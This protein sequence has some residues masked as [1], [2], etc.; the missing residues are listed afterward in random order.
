MSEHLR[1]S[2]PRQLTPNACKRK[3]AKNN[4]VID[5]GLLLVCIVWLVA[6][7]PV[8]PWQSDCVAERY[9]LSSSRLDMRLRVRSLEL[10]LSS[11]SLERLSRGTVVGTSELRRSVC[12]RDPRA[13]LTRIRDL[14]IHRSMRRRQASARRRLPRTYLRRSLANQLTMRIWATPSW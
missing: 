12:S 6:S 4:E 14:A 1:K 10:G 3:S 2:G 7:W 13:G 5:F 9:T 8:L 11:T